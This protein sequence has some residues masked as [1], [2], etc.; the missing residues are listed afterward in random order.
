MNRS[1]GLLAATVLA[2]FFTGCGKNPPSALSQDSGG[3]ENADAVASKQNPADW[4]KDAV[5]YQI[6]PDR[7][8]NGDPSNDPTRASLEWPINPSAKWRVS[9][10]TGDWYARDTWEAEIGPDFYR[11]GVLDRRYGGDLQG[12]LDKLDYLADLG[13]NAI[14]FNPLFYSRSLHKYDGNSYHHIDPFFG[15]DPRGDLALIE[16]ETG[17][18]PATWQWTA[19]D[20][21]LLRVLA[22]AHR[23][24]MRVILDGVFNHTGRDFFAFRDLQKNQARSSYRDWYV[25]ESFDD[26]QTKRDEFDYKG[27]WGHKTLP[28]FAAS[29]DGN[30]IAPGP[31]AYIFAATKRWMNPNGNIADGIDGWRLDVAPERPSKFWRDWNAHVRALNPNAYT[32]C[33]IWSDPSKLIADGGFSACMNYFAFAIPVKGFLIDGKIRVSD[34]ARLLDTRRAALPAGA[35]DVMQNLLDS[36]DTDR[37]ASM[38]VNAD[39]ASYSDP[40]KI[41]YNTNG[42]TGPS[43]AY[44]IRKPN[45]RERAIQRL[46]VLFQ[47]TYA[48]APMI[49]YGDEGGMWGGND[50]DDRLPMVW[51]D[52]KFAPQ[53]IDPRGT[54]RKPDEIA[55]DDG[56]FQFYKLAIALRRKHEVLR[57]GEFRVAGVFDDAQTFAFQRRS[58]SGNLLVVLNRSG[59][60]QSVRI[61]LPS[62]D[63]AKY[64]KAKAIFSTNGDASAIGVGTASGT[65]TVKLPPLSGAVIAP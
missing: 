64:A 39:I 54:P 50:P 17:G 8:R 42:V 31:K 26:P 7:F 12:V 53:G 10:W 34:F 24:G 59:Q 2:V 11:D 65:L 25:V 44:K 23:R 19:A 62:E 51:S 45:P 20:K 18:D 14:Y 13:I 3:G 21:L 6:F 61:G 55:F 40:E 4:P 37:V 58:D 41:D 22:E 38:I 32:S 28:V 56:V 48:G 16:K 33:E 57:R 43:T 49:Y 52:L 46:I 60:A 1:T 5:W 63:A 9:P 30:D 29:E 36:H 15:P 27:W 47:A 35:A